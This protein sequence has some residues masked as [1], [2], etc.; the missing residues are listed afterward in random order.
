LANR[1]PREASAWLYFYEDFLDGYDP[2]LRRAT[3]SYYTPVEVVDPMV[4][5]VD[6]LVRRRLGHDHGL[7]SPAV[8]VVDPGAGTGTFLFRIIDRIAATVDD[9]EGPGAVGPRLRDAARRLVGFELQAGPY[10]VAEMRLSSEFVRRGA[11]LGTGDLRLFLTDT[12][13]NPY[14]A[15][16][17]M[18]AVYAAIARSRQQASLVKRE[19]PVMVVIGNPPYRERSRGRGGWVE[20]GNPGANQEAPLLAFVPPRAWSLGVHVKHLYN[21]YVYF[22]RWATWKVFEHHPAD[23]GVVAFITVAGFLHGPGFAAMRA[24]LRH[25]ADAVWVVDCSPEGHQPEVATRVFQGVQ[26]PV[27]ITIAVRDGTTDAQ[28][29]AP[30]RFTAVTGRREDKF[31]ALAALELDGPGWDDCRTDWTAPFLPAGAASWTSLPALDELL[32]WSGSGTMPGRTWVTSPSPVT[33][34]LRWLRLIAAASEEKR[35][36]LDEHPTDR[37]IH[38]RLSDNLPGY[39]APS[40]SLADEGGGCPA[41]ERYGWRSFDRQWI[42]PDKR[43]INRPNPSLWQVRRAPGQVYLTALM[44]HSPSGGPGAT[45]TAL[46]P[47]LHHYKGSF[48]G[49]TWPLWLDAAGT[50][51]NV[52]PGL[53]DRLA[54]QYGLDVSGPDLFAFVAAVVA[55]PVTPNASASTSASPACGFPSLQ[56]PVYLPTPPKPEGGCCGCRPSESAFLIRLR[57]DQPARLARPA[58]DA[59]G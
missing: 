24:Y 43:V 1:E 3:G 47:D 53:L 57:V 49:R 11:A 30:V 18:P 38:T 34:R 19:E 46:V 20:L 36:L 51:P 42:V 14:E 21:P 39:P 48:G 25:T 56:T 35:I 15:D 7:A 22:W 6:D 55:H 58:S 28:T 50:R 45:F 59:R 8:T 13:S 4:R 9:L 27:C 17:H 5:L 37:T 2:A 40:T 26:Q 52:V 29:P 16:Q 44:A 41:P 54:A 31:A 23:K 33:L 12:L 32:A 10:S